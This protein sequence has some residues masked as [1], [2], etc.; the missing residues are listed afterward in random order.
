MNSY[1]VYVASSGSDSNPGTMAE[2]VQSLDE[3]LSRTRKDAHSDDE[4]RIMVREGCYYDVSLTLTSEDGNL[5]IEAYPG[6]QPILYGGHPVTSWEKDGQLYSAPLKDV[7]DRSRDFRAIEVDGQFRPRARY[8]ESGALA[9]LNEFNVD[10]VSTYAGGW[11]RPPTEE[12]MMILKVKQDDFAAASDVDNAELTIYHEWDESLVGLQEADAETGTIRFSNQPG[13]PPGAFA[14]RNGNARTYVVWNTRAGVTAPGK[15]YL[16]RTRSRLVYWPKATEDMENLHIVAPSREQVIRLEPGTSKLKFKGLTLSCSAAP[17][18]GGGFASQEASAAVAGDDV[19]D[20]VFEN[21][22]I[23]NTSGWA[24]K[25]NGSDV[26]WIGCDVHHTG[27]GGIQFKGEGM[28]LL[29]SKI[30]EVGMCYQSAVAVHCQGKDNVIRHN[31]IHD[32]P[33]CGIVSTSPDTLVENNLLHN[34]M[35]FMKDGAAIYIA[36][37]SHNTIVRGN[38]VFSRANEQV[39]RYAYY[40]DEKC[41]DCVVDNNLA[42]N[43]GVPMLS[44]MTTGCRFIN[45]IFLDQGPQI[46]SVLNSSGTIFERNVLVAQTIELISPQGNPLGLVS[47]EF[48]SH[49]YMKLFS[50][51]DGIVSLANNMFCTGSGAPPL[52]KEYLHYKTIG[53]YALEEKDGNCFADPLIKDAAAGDFSYQEGS[54]ARGLG[55]H[56]LSFADVGCTSA[57]PELF[58][59]YYRS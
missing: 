45:N 31:E 33:Y 9:H 26:Q 8:P 50:K 23:R 35:T 15:W 3:A 24:C 28:Q 55:I 37:D 40:L 46:V 36:M 56:P 11:R 20:V 13:H 4:K 59:R 30:H 49:P 39:R 2:P 22:T 41:V 43:L 17:L 58:E 25:L 48:D 27:A 18:A 1:I 14:E 6:E 57:F 54:P 38:A 5:T 21:M 51:S 53:E 42:V 7:S 52:F 16:D 19:H 34:T 32:I 47:E 12:E 29:H 44:H 10:W